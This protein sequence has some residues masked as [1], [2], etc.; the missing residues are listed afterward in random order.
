MRYVSQLLQ[1]RLPLKPRFSGL[2]DFIKVLPKKLLVFL[3][4]I[5]YIGVTGEMSP[6][7]KSKLGIFNSLNFFQFITGIVVPVMGL[8]SAQK[9]PASGWII[10][11][12]PALVSVFVL[13]L[14]YCH[15]HEL[16]LLT[17]F[18]LYPFFICFN[19][20]NGISLGVELSFILYGILSV[21]F[22][23]DIGYMI[24]SI[25]FSM[26][27]YFFLSVIL[28]KYIYQLEQINF[29]AY[30]VNQGLAIVYIFYGLYLIKTENANYNTTLYQTNLE[31][32]KQ[33]NQ[34]KQQAEEL[35][36]LNSLK[37]KLFS[38]ISH[39]LK[40]PMYALRNLF[41]NIHSQDMPAEEIKELIPEVKKD[42]N[43]TVSLMENLLQW[44][45]SQMKVHSVRPQLINITDLIDEVMHLL[46]LQAEAK[47]IYIGKKT[48]GPVYAWADHDMINLVL[49]NLVSN[50][51]KFT[52]PGGNICIGASE[53]ST[54]AE[55]YVQ[56]SGKGMSAKEVKKVNSEEFYTTNGTAQEQGTGIG[57]MLC[58][59][60]LVKNDGCLRIESEP[61]KGSTFSFTLP[62]AD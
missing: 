37:N 13:V 8:I 34:L 22:I 62:L 42:L 55:V 10:V 12:L 51:I 27:S 6:I 31:I 40:A 58:R 7:E 59:E 41:D 1:V 56:D 60:F 53:L 4:R 61:G 33:S 16:A 48:S 29:V 52:P 20:I 21:F 18:V 45:K 36:Q 25:S 54:F 9:F 46:H 3:N 39:D 43:Y 17:Y 14:N 38:V 49:R 11:C 44:A 19:Y 15:K 35:D 26:I 28:K 30:L 47:R 50:A 24:F 5:K 32:Q 23:Q 2:G 57:L